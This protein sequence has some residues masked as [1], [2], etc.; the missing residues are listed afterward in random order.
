MSC[1]S[2]SL[3]SHGPLRLMPPLETH[4]TPPKEDGSFRHKRESP[5]R[6]TPRTPQQPSA[7]WDRSTPS[8]AK[9]MKENTDGSMSA[10][11]TPA[12]EASTPSSTVASTPSSSASTSTPSTTTPRYYLRNIFSSGLSTSTNSVCEASSDTCETSMSSA[13]NSPERVQMLFQDQARDDISRGASQSPPRKFSLSTPPGPLDETEE[14]P[15]TIVAKEAVGKHTRSASLRV[16]D[17]VS[18]PFHTIQRQRSYSRLHDSLSLEGSFKPSCGLSERRRPSRGRVS[19]NISSDASISS[20]EKFPLDTSPS[21]S[22]AG[23]VVAYT[24]YTPS[25]HRNTP[26]PSLLQQPELGGGGGDRKNPPSFWMKLLVRLAHTKGLIWL[27]CLVA[28]TSLC[29]TVITNRSMAIAEIA[30]APLAEPALVSFGSFGGERG[31]LMRPFATGLRGN[32]ILSVGRSQR[33]GPLKLHHGNEHHE[34]KH[35]GK[36]VDDNKH[37]HEAAPPQKKD[38]KTSHKIEDVEK[39]KHHGDKPSKD[40]R[41]LSLTALS[42]RQDHKASPSKDIKSGPTN[43]AHETSYSETHKTH[44]ESKHHVS[45]S[46]KNTAHKVARLIPTVTRPRKRLDSTQRFES[47]DRRLYRKPS[48]ERKAGEAGRVVFL[49]DSIAHIPSSRRKVPLYPADFTDN[50]QLYS[51]LDSADER[52]K[53]MELRD[54]YEQ[55]ECVPM[56]DWQTTFHPS[57]NVVHELGL[58]DI[59]DENGDDA[60]LFGTNGYWRNAWKV[61]LLGGRNHLKDR[62]TIVLKTLK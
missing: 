20:E 5:E 33:E 15:S 13:S 16:G 47:Q 60:L 31:K 21:P 10:A 24:P 19:P 45:V 50:T 28:L 2:S 51:I 49:D 30:V 18:F 25:H 22:R 38:Q 14:F 17:S 48:H 32:L 9:L 57:C 7:P 12:T 54:P 6:S 52:V 55:G 43:H 56:Q 3:R 40:D 35:S 39:H 4:P 42:H 23:P 8:Y 62:D 26:R 11:V 41:P 46:N 36:H 27:L 34:K 59:G 53:S 44:H 29:M 61:D 37:G 58:A 1:Q